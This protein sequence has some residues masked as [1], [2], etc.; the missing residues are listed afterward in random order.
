MRGI[1]SWSAYL[2]VPA[3]RPHADRALR[4]PGRREGHPHGRVVRRGLHHHGGRG[5]AP[6]AARSRPGARRSCCSPPASRPTPTRPTRPRST[7]RCGS[8]SS[9]PA[10]DLGASV[11]SAVG[12]LLLGPD[13]SRQPR[14]WSRPT[15]APGCRAAATKPRA[16]TPPPRSWSA[17][18]R[19][20]RSSPSSSARRASPTSSSS[21]GARRVSNERRS[22]TR[23]S[24][25][26]A[27]CPSACR[28]GTRRWSR[29]GSPPATSPPPPSSRRASGWRAR[30]A[31]SST[32]C[33]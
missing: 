21:A 8:G 9:V 25:R 24:A 19:P 33:T 15:C 18:T 23:S 7:P 2:P 11:R 5:G 29:P 6:R 22:G 31:A 27:T 13:R 12:A 20:A 3:A 14:S 10:F 16:V 1:L 32:A 26:S 4:R 28:R 17:T 30:S